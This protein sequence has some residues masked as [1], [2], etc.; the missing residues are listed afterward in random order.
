MRG[1]DERKKLLIRIAPDS[2]PL[3]WYHYRFRYLST[4]T[5]FSKSL[6]KMIYGKVRD[7]CCILH[8]DLPHLPVL[9][10]TIK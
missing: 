2:D 8:D 10:N 1:S 7:A 9:T 6:L 5:V 3:H 4:K